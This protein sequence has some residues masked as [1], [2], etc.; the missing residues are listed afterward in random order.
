MYGTDSLRYRNRESH[1]GVMPEKWVTPG[2]EE[3]LQIC[4]LRRRLKTRPLERPQAH[5][6]GSQFSA[7][8]N[9]K[10]H[11]QCLP[12]QPAETLLGILRL[13]N[14]RPV[15]EQRF[16]EDEDKEH[17]VDAVLLAETLAGVLETM[18]T[19]MTMTEESLLEDSHELPPPTLCH[20]IHPTINST[21]PLP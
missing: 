11:P 18:M 7:Q 21:A 1:G 13:V 15:E 4:M 17:A 3:N 10:N 5:T 16:G 2:N 9:H 19:M 12:D 6:A 20:S 8:T 14:Q